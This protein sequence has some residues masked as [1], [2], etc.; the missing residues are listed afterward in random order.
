MREAEQPL[1]VQVAEALGWTDCHLC[2]HKECGPGFWVGDVPVVD[3]TIR[4]SH[5]MPRYDTDWAATGPLIEKYGI[6]I[7]HFG[8]GNPADCADPMSWFAR[9]ERREW[10]TWDECEAATPLLAVCALILLLK[11]LGELEPWMKNS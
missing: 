8:D 4:E 9:H 2:G 1:H 7:N 11:S 6:D 3:G 5:L 10:G